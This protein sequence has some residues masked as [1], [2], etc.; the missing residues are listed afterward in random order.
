MS[1]PFRSRIPY[2]PIGSNTVISG[3]LKVKIHFEAYLKALFA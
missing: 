3:N 2:M 1:Q